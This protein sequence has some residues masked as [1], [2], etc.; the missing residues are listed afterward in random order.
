MVTDPP[1]GVK[2]DPAW[3]TTPGID[4]GAHRHGAQRRPRRLARGVG[5]VS[6]R[7]RLR[8]ARRR[9]W[10]TVVDS[11]AT[12]GFAIRAQII[13]A[14]NRFALS[15]GDYHWQHE[16]CWYAVRRRRVRWQ[17][18]RKQTTLWQIATNSTTTRRRARD[19][20][21]RRV[22]AA[23]DSQQQSPR[24]RGVR[25][26]RRQRHHTHRCRG[27]G[28]RCLGMEIEPR[29]CDVIVGVGRSSP[30]RAPPSTATAAASKR[31]AQNA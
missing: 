30:G 11:L 15:R 6:R 28:R 9:S 4:D 27:V 24:R 21:A 31:S 14:K 25:A 13:W 29:Y 19:A 20:E 3:R 18:A 12:C 7:C 8:V 10:P 23:A 22:H 1:Y 5:A 26:V 2:Y 16:P 17:G